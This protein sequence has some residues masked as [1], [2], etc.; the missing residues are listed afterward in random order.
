MCD[1]IPEGARPSE[2][3]TR[4]VTIKKQNK[5]PAKPICKPLALNSLSATLK[6]LDGKCRRP[7]ILRIKLSSVLTTSHEIYVKT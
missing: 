3:H 6:E 7:R 2:R 5:N 4:L 1:R